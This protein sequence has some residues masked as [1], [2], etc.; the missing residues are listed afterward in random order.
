[1]ASKEKKTATSAVEKTCELLACASIPLRE[2]G[3]E[4]F[5]VGIASGCL[6]DYGGRR[7]ILTVAHATGNMGRWAIE[8]EYDHQRGAKLWGIGAMHFL[9]MLS[10][11]D[12]T[13]QTL[14]LAYTTV[15]G[16]LQPY[17]QP[18]DEQAQMVKSLPRVIFQQPEL[19]YVPSG[20]KLYGFA[21]GVMQ[22]EEHHFG[23]LWHGTKLICYP[24]LTFVG[25]DEQFYFFKLPFAHPG[26]EFFKGTSG[27]PICDRKRNIAA[28]VC[29]PGKKPDTIRGIKM[30]YFRS[31]LDVQ[32]LEPRAE[33]PVV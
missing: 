7:W 17:F 25:E 31:A 14:D 5:P 11:S 9:D 26:H 30:H 24:T 10:L 21:G 23:K 28:L 22:T 15:P 33:Q 16:D 4:N 19:R 8:M 12:G 27:A 6:I 20:T 13:G 3:P 29:G 32:L 18:R 1:V 2:M